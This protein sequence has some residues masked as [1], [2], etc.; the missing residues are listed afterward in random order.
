LQQKGVSQRYACRLLRLNRS[1]FQYQPR[2]DRNAELPQ[3]LHAS[4]RRRRWGFRKAW[5]AL[6]RKGQTVNIKRV[7]RL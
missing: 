7:Q 1:T 4:Q 3:Q 6:R 2:P 5:D